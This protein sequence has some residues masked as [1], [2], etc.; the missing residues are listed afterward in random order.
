MIV[1]MLIQ[2]HFDVFFLIMDIKYGKYP[3]NYINWLIAVFQ[4]YYC[5]FLIQAYSLP[6]LRD[7]K[8]WEQFKVKFLALTIARFVLIWISYVY[9]DVDALKE[10]IWSSIIPFLII[11]WNTKKASLNC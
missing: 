5:Y 3:I 8:H 10:I 6:N 2:L 11:I 7:T 9:Q 1:L 4:I